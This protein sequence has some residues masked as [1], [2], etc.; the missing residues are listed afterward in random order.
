MSVARL[1]GGGLVELT[2][3]VIVLFENQKFPAGSVI[4]LGS[5]SLLHKVGLTVYTMDWN[6]CLDIL[7]KRIG[8]IQI[9]PLIPVIKDYI[10]GSLATNLIALVFWLTKQYEG[11]TLGLL[12]VWSLLA[13]IVTDL[14]TLGCPPLQ[15]RCWLPLDHAQIEMYQL[16]P[17]HVPRV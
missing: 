10:P 16:A 8:G 13:G 12:S 2:D 1:E 3:F 9:C 4:C 17:R 7:T 14:T 15:S 11:S 6:R 5:A